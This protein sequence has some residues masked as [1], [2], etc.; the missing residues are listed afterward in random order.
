MFYFTLK[1]DAISCKRN[2]NAAWPP[3]GLWEMTTS[4]QRKWH[5]ICD[6]LI[7]FTVD[8]DHKPPAAKLQNHRVSDAGEKIA[9]SC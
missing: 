5:E 1:P 7:R 2:I 3:P 6:E 9:D 8:R 4:V